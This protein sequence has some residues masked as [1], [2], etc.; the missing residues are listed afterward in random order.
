MKLRILIIFLLGISLTTCIDPFYLELDDYESILVV[1]GMVTN[2]LAPNTIQLSRTFQND[3]TAPVLL[4]HA[5]VSVSD[6][7]G[8]ITVFNEHE[9]GIYKSD[10]SQFTGRVGGTYTLHIK[11]EEGLEYASDPC[12]MTEVPDIDNIYYE[13]DSEFYD[14][15]TVEE[16]GLRIYLDAENNVETSQ[17]LRWEFEEVWKFRV[18]Y[19]IFH[20]DLGYREYKTQHVENNICWRYERSK[21][22][23]I[24]S[25]EEQSSGL[26]RRKPIHFVAPGRSD[27]LLKQYSIRVNQYSLSQEE[28]SYWEQLKEL[29]ESEGDVFEKQPFPILGNISCINREHEKVL[30]YFQVSAVNYQRM[31]ITQSQLSELDFPVYEYPCER[32][33]KYSWRF[34]ERT[35]QEL[36]YDGYVLFWVQEDDFGYP[37]SFQFTSPECADCSLTGKPEQPDFWVDMD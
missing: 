19:P 4:S 14:N 33:I 24:H 32:I 35:Y 27:R 9:P 15:G 28:F 20:E 11:T 1:E 30:G 16:P 37:I 7:L 2:E 18:P 21:Q 25:A 26:I 31:Y 12:T 36:L 5:E 13:P 34:T 10:P 17:F 6:A 29:T 8:V 22:I 3:T 23:L